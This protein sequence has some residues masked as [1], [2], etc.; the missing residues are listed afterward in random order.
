MTH[1]TSTARVSQ[2]QGFN[3]LELLVVL[4]LIAVILG[5]AMPAGQAMM[6]RG[7]LRAAT[8]EVY[9]AL[10]FT[11]NEAVRLRQPASICASSN[12]T[13]S[14]CSDSAADYLGIFSSSSG[15]NLVSGKASNPVDL[16]TYNA[17]VRLINAEGSRVTFQPMGNRQLAANADNPLFFEVTVGSHIRQVEVCFNGRVYI[18]QEAG[19]SQ[20]KGG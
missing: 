15:F 19:E 10:L 20:C 9:S 8:N 4:G 14:T 13:P 5:V 7:H 18:R 6:E 3:L 2:Q 17:R 16:G 11:R 1:K 12:S